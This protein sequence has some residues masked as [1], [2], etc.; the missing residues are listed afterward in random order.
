[1]RRVARFGRHDSV[2]QVDI[3][4]GVIRNGRIGDTGNVHRPVGVQRP[5][6]NNA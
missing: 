4:A 3:S 5:N 1:M 6:A 2:H